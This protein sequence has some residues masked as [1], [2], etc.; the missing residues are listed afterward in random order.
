MMLSSKSFL[1]FGADFESCI[2]IQNAYLWP[3]CVE[4]YPVNVLTFDKVP[5]FAFKLPF[6]YKSLYC[7]RNEFN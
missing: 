3:F 6:R 1:Y 7:K 2:I 5:V 4:T